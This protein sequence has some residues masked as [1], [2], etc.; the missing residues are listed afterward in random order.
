[1]N[2]LFL[3]RKQ[4]LV[5]TP[6]IINEK[7]KQNRKK[8]FGIVVTTKHF[9]INKKPQCASRDSAQNQNYYKKIIMKNIPGHRINIIE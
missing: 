7:I 4:V 3:K 1:M 6:S 8:N 9:Q 5:F 2:N